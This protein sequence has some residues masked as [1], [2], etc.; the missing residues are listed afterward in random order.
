MYLIRAHQPDELGDDFTD[1]PLQLLCQLQ[2]SVM[3]KGVVWDRPGLFAYMRSYH[4]VPT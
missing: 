2:Y 1:G 3:G 4:V